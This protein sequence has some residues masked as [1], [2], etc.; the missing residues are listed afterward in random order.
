MI[1]ASFRDFWRVFDLFLIEFDDLAK[2]SL[3][4]SSTVSNKLDRQTYE[5]SANIYQHICTSG[6][7][8]DGDDDHESGVGADSSLA[9]SNKHE[10]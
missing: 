8:D 6:D 5:T 10:I 3:I 7:D 4:Y 2:R 9:V 1:S